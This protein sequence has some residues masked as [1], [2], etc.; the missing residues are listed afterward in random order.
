MR[1]L[2][3]PF[4]TALALGLLAGSTVGVAAQDDDADAARVVPVS[5]TGRLAGGPPA[6]E[7]AQTIET[8]DGVVQRR[9]QAFEF[10]LEDVSD[11]RLGG[12]MIR[13]FDDDEYPGPE[14]SASFWIQTMTIR[15]E[16]DGGAWQG[17][18][19]YFSDENI[20]IEENDQVDSVV[21]LVGEDDYEG[22][23]A[24]YE[25]EADDFRG[26]HGVIFPTP[27]PPPPPTP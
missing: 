27:P 12:R 5:F 8:V 14:E 11:P 16:N 22:L 26:F 1:K 21:V 9:G 6:A 3:I 23:Y 10:E 18:R 4:M 13:F 24:A 15:I 17:S 19:H 2:Q 25:E 20:A 7:R